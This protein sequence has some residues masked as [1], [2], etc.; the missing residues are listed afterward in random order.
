MKNPILII[1]ATS[2][3]ARAA[4]CIWAKRGH[5]IFLASRERSEL[6]RLSSDIKIR[7]DVTVR[8]AT[9]NIEDFNSHQNFLKGVIQEMG[10]L[11]GV[12]LVSGYLGDQAIAIGDFKEAK[13]II[14]IN[15]TGAC[16]ILSHCANALF[17]KRE[18]F[19]AAVSSV[20]GDRGRQSNYIYG[21]AKGGL[22]IFLQGLRNRLS[23]QNI[24]VL[25]VKPG[26]MDT[27]MTYGRQ[28]MFLI[29]SPQK[30]GKAIVEAVD[31]RKNVIYVPWFWRL[32]MMI[33]CAIPE[34]LFKR[35]K[36]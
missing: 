16:S 6:E 3:L 20:A 24:T 1:G 32:I 31:S 11:Y 25:T 2:S 13:A 33:I 29:A 5:S 10:G 8:Y 4:A 30:V 7:Y 28:G 12:L 19:I 14:D 22:N 9:F 35:L 27:A 26:F 18:G 34:S 23:P 21:S 36:L 15:Y 17:E